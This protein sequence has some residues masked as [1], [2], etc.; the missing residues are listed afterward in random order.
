VGEVLR[1]TGGREALR[2]L[3]IGTGDPAPSTVD[4]ILTE[5][6]LPD[7]DGIEVTRRIKADPRF[8]D[9]PVLV[10][11]G[12]TNTDDLRAAFAAGA[13]DY[14]V[15]PPGDV[16]LLARV[17][18]ALR[19]KRELDARAQ[20]EEDLREVTRQLEWAIRELRRVSG[21]DAV[22]GIA[23]RSRFDDVFDREWRRA[24]RDRMPVSLLFI[25]VEPARGPDDPH[26][27]PDARFV[28]RVAGA[29][30]SCLYRP[31]DF[32]ARLALSSFAVVLPQTDLEGALVVA[33]RVRA[34]I[35]Q[36]EAAFARDAGH[37]AAV[38]TGVASIASTQDAEPK[39]LIAAADRALQAAK[40][41]RRAGRGEGDVPPVAAAPL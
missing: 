4:L 24:R 1:L 9:V 40:A 27:A 10:V 15:K 16:D 6:L 11:T 32:A 35:E 28:R 23:N 2:Y 34:R 20:R 5:I 26:G 13:S 17:E 8:T 21:A 33:R 18:A 37:R 25:D 38:D 30:Q 3:G 22:A 31:A 41:Q 14:I 19:R 39:V 29:I 7:L 12:V 36:D